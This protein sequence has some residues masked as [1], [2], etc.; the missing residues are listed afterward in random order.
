[1]ET[2]RSDKRVT[3]GDQV[4]QDSKESKSYTSSTKFFKEL[5]EEKDVARG[6]GGP[7]KGGKKKKKGKT[8]GQVG[9]LKL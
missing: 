3:T 8:S 1:M 5:Q 7:K 2:L 6:G 4:A 9:N